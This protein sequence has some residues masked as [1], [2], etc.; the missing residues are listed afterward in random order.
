M[1]SAELVKRIRRFCVKHSDP[2]TV[3]KYQRFFKEGYDAYGLD[4]KTYEAGIKSLVD[5][6]VTLKLILDAAPELL[7]SGKYEE[8][9]FVL[10][11]VKRSNEKYTAKTFKEIER[12]FDYGIIN[13][14]HADMLAGDIVPSFILDNVVP[15]AALESWQGAENKFQRRVSAVAL[16]KILKT[17]GN[18]KKL[19]KFIEPLMTDSAREVHQGV[20]WFLR[21]A[22]VIDKAETE[23]FLLKWKDTAP[24]LIFQYATEKMTPA[25]RQRFRKIKSK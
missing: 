20:G 16:I 5:D 4:V 2:A 17:T 13:W 14:A 11:L 18:P 6:G 21:E 1:T 9:S 15:L 23:R 19:I 22:W 25:E 10:S 12:F 7:K 3:K 8:T 24:R